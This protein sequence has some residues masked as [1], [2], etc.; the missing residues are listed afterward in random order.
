MT[1]KERITTAMRNGVPD[2]VPVTL[3]LSEIIPVQKFTDDYIEFFMKAKI[4]H[5]KARFE[6]EADYFKA[7]AF[8]HLCHNAS[9]YD[10]ECSMKVTRETSDEML[11]TLTHHTVMGDLSA[12]MYIAKKT[13][14]SALKPFVTD[15]EKDIPKVRELLKNPDSK[16][17]DEIRDGLR[18][19][20][21]RAHAGFWIST[22]VDWWGG[23]RGTQEMVMDL[24]LYPEIMDNLFKE[25][26]EYAVSLTEHVLRGTEADSVGLGGSSTSMSVIS[27][28]L[29]RRFSLPFGN[30]VC[31]VARRFGRPS[32]YHMCGRSRAA[33]PVTAEMGA[34]CFDALEC[35][36]TGD[37]DLS[38]VKKTFGARTA[39]RGNVNSIHVMM[40]GTTDDVRAAVKNCLN[41][42]KTGGGYILGVGDQTPAGTSDENLHAFVEAGLEFGRY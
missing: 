31:A 34:D 26:T 11:Y 28:D 24:M 23:L 13:P 38:E 4:P 5:W 25:Y 32:L 37:V 22:P 1:P 41:A 27:P 42:A 40:S 19:M 16:S 35:P 2:R 33:L 3:G 12:E 29:H 10:P 18:E 6:I 30:A 9:P 8:V 20:G 39:L 21:S 17:L 7:D 14:A 36:P 15:L